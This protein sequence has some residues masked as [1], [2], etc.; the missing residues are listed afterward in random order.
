MEMDG[1]SQCFQ[2]GNDL[3]NLIFRETGYYLNCFYAWAAGWVVLQTK[4]RL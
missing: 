1:A 4:D 2:E 3:S